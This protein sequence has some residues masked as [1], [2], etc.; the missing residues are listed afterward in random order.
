VPTDGIALGTI[1]ALNEILM[2]RMSVRSGSLGSW[3]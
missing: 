1:A 3:L 2:A